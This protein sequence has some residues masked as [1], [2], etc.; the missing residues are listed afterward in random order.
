M[1]CTNKSI[2]PIL[3][4]PCHDLPFLESMKLLVKCGDTWWENVVTF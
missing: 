4:K 1:S 2:I 3:C